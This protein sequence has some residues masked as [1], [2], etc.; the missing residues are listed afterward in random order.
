MLAI[1]LHAPMMAYRA[2]VR[3]LL[4]TLQVQLGTLNARLAAADVPGA[5]AAWLAAH[6]SWLRIGQDDGA[7]GAFGGI[8]RQIDGTAAGLVDGTAD[9]AFTGF[10]RWSSICGRT[11]M[12]PPRPPTR[13]PWPGW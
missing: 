11:A 12:S 9:P 4:G 7:Y 13:P 2:Y 5:K 1:E 3:R 6:L 8:G 10:T